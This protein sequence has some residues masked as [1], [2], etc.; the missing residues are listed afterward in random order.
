MTGSSRKRSVGRIAGAALAVTVLG[1]TGC[2]SD[3]D[4]GT[5]EK[6][7]ASSGSSA[8]K[9]SGGGDG[10]GEGEGDKGA[11]KG[12]GDEAASSPPSGGTPHSTAREAVASWVGAVVKGQPK[13]ACLVM[14]QPATG[15]APAQV[16]NPKRCNSNEAD[17]VKM[18]DGIG[19]FR[20][21]FTPKPPS[22][23]PKVQVAQVPATGGK[24]VVPAEKV[25]ID[26]KRL[27][28][29]IVANSTGVKEGQVD[30]KF[31]AAEIQNAWYVTDFDFNFG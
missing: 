12:E 4:S 14:A 24:A 31:K 5:G 23:D 15:S 20:E 26:G 29:I 8:S 19:R 6:D 1:V 21:A 28:K 13:K 9:D 27:D 10:K 3:K 30:V 25:T 22:S 7:P 11:G 18:R 17:A 2:S 16:G